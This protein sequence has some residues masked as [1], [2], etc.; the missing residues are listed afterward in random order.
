MGASS[1]TSTLRNDACAPP[2]V[3]R[4]AQVTSPPESKS[5][6]QAAKVSSSTVTSTQL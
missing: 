1:G 3:S 5:T 6:P 2:T 4:L